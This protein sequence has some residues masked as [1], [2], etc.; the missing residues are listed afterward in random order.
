MVASNCVRMAS[1]ARVSPHLEVSAEMKALTVVKLCARYHAP[2]GPVRHLFS[3]SR[4][5]S[6][7]GEYRATM[8]CRL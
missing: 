4:I 2:A 5:S 7:V 3:T 8:S 1:V 6:V